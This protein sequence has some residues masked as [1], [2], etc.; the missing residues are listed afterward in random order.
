VLCA[1]A[2]G[3]IALG[4]YVATLLPD[5]GG[6]ED[7]PKFQFLGYV[8]GTAH[9]PGYPLYVMLSHL[10]VKLP[11]G[12]IAYRANLFSAVMAALACVLAYVI[13][14]QLGVRR[15]PA[16]CATAGLASG[17]SFWTSAVFAEVYSL[18]AVMAA[19]SVSLLLAWGAH[20]GTPLLLAAVAAFG[21]GL[22]NHLTI[23]GLV[24]AAAWYV[25]LR[26]RRGLRARVVVS[27][28][29]VLLVCVS[30]YGFIIVRT[31]QKAPY[32][33]S[34]ARTLGELVKV[35]TAERFASQR[36]AFDL[37][38]LATV[39]VPAA[40]A[41]I[42]RD[43]GAAGVLLL[44]AGLIAA[45]RRRN[46]GIGLLA[47]A[48]GG[49]FSMVVNLQGDT[50]GFITPLMPLLWPV[51]GYGVDAVA[52]SLQ[53]IRL[54]L[55]IDTI[56]KPA[57]STGT[58]R[59]SAGTIVLLAAAAIPA[60][61]L[62]T[63]YT[64]CDQSRNTDRAQFL[65]A[66]YGQLPRRAALV[67][68][69]Y[70]LD[71]ELQYLV[72]TDPDR[73]NTDIARLGFGAEAVR[74]AKR[75]NRR[76]FALGAAATYLGAHGLRFER[77]RFLGPPLDEWLRG[78]PDGSIVVGA[79]AYTPIPRE[80]FGAAQRRAG[81]SGPSLPF[82]AFGL[83]TGGS[84]V[85]SRQEDATAVLVVEQDLL[86]QPLPQLAGRLVASADS[87]QARLELAGRTIAE[88]EFGLVLSVFSA[89]GTLM[90]ALEFPTGELL[91]VPFDTA[92]YELE[93]EAACA[94]VGT[95]EWSDISPALDTGSLLTTVSGLGSLALELEL[96]ADI[97]RE[98]AVALLDGGSIRTTGSSRTPDG[99]TIL[100]TE[101][102]R[103]HFRR[104]LF[105][106]AFESAGRPGRAHVQPG[107]AQA[108]VRLCAHTPAPLSS[109]GHRGV[110]RP[111]AEGEAY[112]GAGWSGPVGSATGP[113]RR[114]ERRATLLLPLESASGYGA[115][116]DVLSEPTTPVEI[117]F[118]GKSVGTCTPRARAPCEVTLPASLV[119]AGINALT[120]L[121]H[122]PPDGDL[123][124]LP[125][126]FRRAKLRSLSAPSAAR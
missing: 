73:A 95:D 92:V 68:E 122:D 20:G 125:L 108:S 15:W 17:Y 59:L 93:G 115:S 61:N 117:V 72:F 81:V 45:V 105:R 36:F 65:R 118:N 3:V 67:A 37:Q 46:L 64:L 41:I 76:V 86:G 42:A 16:L 69:D 8:L 98:R 52:R 107:G 91:R 121:A 5:L 78:L 80:L 62:T 85:E 14:R 27:A 29:A 126:T 33:E 34:G 58:L 97:G 32:L 53:S 50:N 19:L 51:A 38:T 43:L 90:R 120:L 56:G 89:D 88:V 13:S 123:E 40:A 110:V 84:E 39:Q 104:P 66:M 22:G 35:V 1:V 83:I 94:D 48:A 54:L 9:A 63:N 55:G 71:S 119:R 75:E 4:L 44:A 24:P 111:D 96:P 82:G 11:L 21:L 18:A 124:P 2:V 57:T 77:A 70:A 6:P 25:L 30:Q 106:L 10:F 114:G 79:T 116:L 7:T 99:R 113:I 60:A 109:E 103:S 101:L 47:G 100:L 49:M 112:F 23:V 28:C 74:A 12:T 87:R 31:H 26:D 102:S